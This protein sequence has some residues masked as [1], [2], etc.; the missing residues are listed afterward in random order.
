[1]EIIRILIKVIKEYQINKISK[2]III[3]NIHIILKI[4]KVIQETTKIHIKKIIKILF[5]FN[6]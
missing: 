1:M 5:F 4:N 3:N 2:V 6:F